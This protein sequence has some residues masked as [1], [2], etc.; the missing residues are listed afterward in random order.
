MELQRFK[1]PAYLLEHFATGGPTST[2]E[3]TSANGEPTSITGGPTTTGEPYKYLLAFVIAFN[4]FLFRYQN[5]A[6]RQ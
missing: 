5:S 6:G 2:R 1:P 3:S 4:I